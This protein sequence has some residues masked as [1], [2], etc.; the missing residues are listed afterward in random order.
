VLGP[1]SVA[2]PATL[3]PARQAKAVIAAGLLAVV[4][5]AAVPVALLA[6]AVMMLLGNVVGG[7]ALFGASVLAAVAAVMV[8]GMSGVRHLRRLASRRDY[9]VVRLGRGEYHYD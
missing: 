2:A 3:Q 1:C 9:R 6:G 4:L 7:F 5:V 8:A